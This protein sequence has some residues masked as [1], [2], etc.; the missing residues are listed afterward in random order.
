MKLTKIFGAVLA[1][2]SLAAVMTVATPEVTAQAST[3]M[4]LAQYP[5]KY[6]GTWYYYQKGHYNRFTVAAKKTT[7]RNYVNQKWQTGEGLVKSI[8]LNKTPKSNKSNRYDEVLFMSQGWLMN[9]DRE[10]YRKGAKFHSM[11]TEGY[12]VVTRHY[13]GKKVK[14]LIIN[15]M[16]NY[17]NGE[18]HLFHYYKTKA[19]AKAFNPTG[20][21]EDYPG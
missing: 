5:A 2:L 13:Q 6:R 7:V 20:A 9:A 15:S 3:K 18:C 8:A 16:W 10:T 21:E 19:Q 14:S 1:A 4:S 11:G 17:G 12:K